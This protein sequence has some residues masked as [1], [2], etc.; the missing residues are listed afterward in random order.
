MNTILENIQDD[1]LLK[2][3]ISREKSPST[4]FENFVKEQGF[5]MEELENF[6]ELVELE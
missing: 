1:F 2:L 4:S 3:A 5:S 6:S